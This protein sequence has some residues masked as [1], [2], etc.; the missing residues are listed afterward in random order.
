MDEPR[1]NGR[2][3]E[4]LVVGTRGRLD[5]A[6]RWWQEVAELMPDPGPALREVSRLRALKNI[7]EPAP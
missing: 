5:E 1:Q 7:V 4:V 6:I 2:L 3:R